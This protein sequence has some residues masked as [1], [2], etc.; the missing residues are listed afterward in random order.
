MNYEEEQAEYKKQHEQISRRLLILEE[1]FNENPNLRFRSSLYSSKIYR[2][3]DRYENA[4]RDVLEAILRN[5]YGDFS[6]SFGDSE[7]MLEYKLCIHR[8]KFLELK[9]KESKAD[10]KVQKTF[11]YIDG[12][13]PEHVSGRVYK[14]KDGDGC[15]KFCLWFMIIDAIIIFLWWLVTESH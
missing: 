7:L 9:I 4:R 15:A 12:I 1:M 14:V 8:K 6:S 3:D 5:Q 13:I 2:V 11:D 10:R